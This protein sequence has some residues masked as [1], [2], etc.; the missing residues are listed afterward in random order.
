MIELGGNIQL[1]GFEELQPGLLIVVKK[2]VGSQAKKISEEKGDFDKLIV[3]KEDKAVKSNLVQGDKDFEGK[4]EAEN[5]FFAL[6]QSLE[7]LRKNI[8]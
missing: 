7:D 6:S 8:K 1:D 2:M 3:I 5:L 4:A